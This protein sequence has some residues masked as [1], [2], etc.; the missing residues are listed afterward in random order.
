L[1]KNRKSRRFQPTLPVKT[2]FYNSFLSQKSI[3]ACHIFYQKNEKNDSRAKEEYR[4]PHPGSQQARH[5]VLHSGRHGA[6]T[7]LA[8]EAVLMRSVGRQWEWLV[9]LFLSFILNE[10]N[11]LG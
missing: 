8:E 1:R 7:R 5:L 4:P 3:R 6:A 9:K 2:R 10:E 11:I